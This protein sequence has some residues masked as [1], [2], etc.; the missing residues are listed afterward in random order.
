VAGVRTVQSLRRAIWRMGPKKIY[1]E[2]QICWVLP[3]EKWLLARDMI[4]ERGRFYDPR[5]KASGYESLRT[6]SLY[7]DVN[8]HPCDQYRIVN[9]CTQGGLVSGQ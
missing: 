6:A 2:G 4:E 3:F 8:Q 9:V 5:I 1:V 7:W